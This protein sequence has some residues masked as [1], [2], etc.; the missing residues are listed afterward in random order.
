ME[1][2]GTQDFQVENGD[3]QNIRFSW[4]SLPDLEWADKLS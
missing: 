3:I 4:R 2:L 1:L